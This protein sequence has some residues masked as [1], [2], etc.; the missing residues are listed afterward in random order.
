MFRLNTKDEVPSR[1]NSFNTEI[2]HN[3]MSFPSISVR[4]SR[5]SNSWKINTFTR[6][7]EIFE[8]MDFKNNI[9]HILSVTLDFS[10]NPNLTKFNTFVLNFSIFA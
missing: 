5:N 4:F 2:H 1:T 8:E 9:T 10:R 7:S 3:D 6:K